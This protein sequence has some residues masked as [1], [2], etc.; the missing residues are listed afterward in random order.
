MRA[1]GLMSG[2]SMDGVDVA[3]IDTDGEA[4]LGFGPVGGRPYA[5]E[6]RALLV[7][8]VET[9][10]RLERREDRSGGLD[11][12]ERM[13]TD[14]HASAVE[15]F[16]AVHGLKADDIDLVGFHGQT[17]IHRP[18]RGFTVQLGDG[19]RLAARLGI[20]VVHDLRAAD[21][22]AGGE[23]AP[24]VP[25]FHRAL[26]AH[27]G[28]DLPVVIANIGGVA[29]VTWVGEGD[30]VAFDTGPGNAPI[31]DLVRAR[32]GAACDRD[33][34]LAA[35][36]RVDRTALARLLDHPF[37]DAE[38]PKSLDRD[39]FDLAPVAELDLADAAATLTAFA[40]EALSMAEQHFTFPPRQWI[41]SGGGARNP[42]LM[43]ALASRVA[44]PVLTAD[45]A[46]WNAEH[47]EAQAFAYLAVRSLRGLALTFPTTTGVKAPMTGGVLAQ[48]GRTP[49]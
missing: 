5:A 45:K 27:A 29:N 23:G 35:A 6:E 13:V 11:E 8:A 44:A 15:A 18:E 16:L 7:R 10:R 2:T 39:A 21:M 14:A 4:I 47:V 17:V 33:G 30:P 31:D 36:G 22:A 48:C 32:T 40:A 26:A 49:S 3:L 38:P 42:S 41:V 28:L 9:A 20:D 37:F 34:R 19:E 24:L 12:A 25:V 43:A 46:G 1:I